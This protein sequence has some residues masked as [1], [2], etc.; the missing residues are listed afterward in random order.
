VYFSSISIFPTNFHPHVCRGENFALYQHLYLKVS[1]QYI[2]I[3]FWR[4]YSA[5]SPCA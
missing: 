3:Y 1:M 4:K 5:T 2:P